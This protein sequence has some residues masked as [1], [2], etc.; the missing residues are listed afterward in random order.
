[1]FYREMTACLFGERIF[2]P[3]LDKEE[4]IDYPA[5]AGMRVGVSRRGLN[6]KALQETEGKAR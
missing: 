5:L 1:M 2:R 3:G 4:E 6:E